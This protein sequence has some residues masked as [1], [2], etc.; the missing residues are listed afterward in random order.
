MIAQKTSSTLFNQDLQQFQVGQPNVRH[1]QY[2][3]CQILGI[4][5]YHGKPFYNIRIEGSKMKIFVAGSR[6]E[7]I[8]NA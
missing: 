6:L 7:V 3:P 5:T 8:K 1:K 2:G 4:D